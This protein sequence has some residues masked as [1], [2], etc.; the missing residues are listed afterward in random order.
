MPNDKYRSQFRFLTSPRWRVM[1]CIALVIVSACGRK[2]SAEFLPATSVDLAVVP[3]KT[4][5][6]GFDAIEMRRMDI[7][8]RAEP[9][10]VSGLTSATD[11]FLTEDTIQTNV[12]PCSMA[13]LETNHLEIEFHSD[14]NY[15]LV[16]RHE[17]DLKELL[18]YTNC[19]VGAD[20]RRIDVYVVPFLQAASENYPRLLALQA[21]EEWDVARYGVAS[22]S[23]YGYTYTDSNVIQLRPS[24]LETYYTIDP[25]SGYKSLATG[26]FFGQFG[27]EILHVA[28]MSVGYPE[29]DQ[30]CFFYTSRLEEYMLMHLGAKR[31]FPTS[32]IHISNLSSERGCQPKDPRRIKQ[33]KREL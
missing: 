29:V 28:L 17:G 8:N 24:V 4:V 6:Y 27:H 16:K 25:T 30:H 14:T 12:E 1:F 31:L 19:L 22:K 32:M 18:A 5:G 33:V 7:H 9:E 20:V 15:H 3:S 11:V 10:L 2:P 26:G 23:Y 13:H 21:T